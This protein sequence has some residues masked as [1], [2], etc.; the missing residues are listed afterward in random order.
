MDLLNLESLDILKWDSLQSH[1]DLGKEVAEDPQ[2]FLERITEKP[3]DL[4]CLQATEEELFP[5][6]PEPIS[7]TLGSAVAP[8]FSIPSRSYFCP[9]PFPAST[10][11]PFDIVP[12]SS[13][14]PL[15]DVEMDDLTGLGEE[16]PS[17]GEEWR[18]FNPITSSQ[19]QQK[20][21][22]KENEDVDLRKNSSDSQFSNESSESFGL[23]SSL[24]YDDSNT[25][26]KYCN[27][28]NH[29]IENQNLQQLASIK[30][31]SFNVNLS[32]HDYTKNVNELVSPSCHPMSN[33][34]Y[35]QKQ[36]VTNFMPHPFLPSPPPDYS[37]R[38]NSNGDVSIF[39]QPIYQQ[40]VI[41]DKSTTSS[42]R[43]ETKDEEKI[44][45]CTYANCGKVYAK[46][47]HLKVMSE[48]AKII[49]KLS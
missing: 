31:R 22:G 25:A 43:T 36:I 23:F 11:F 6:S 37:P 44:F 15:L 45:Q 30:S 49:C 32:G 14:L 26:N 24:L 20:I 47:S 1:P 19:H 35:H 3:N 48:S 8:R 38:G 18:A 28:S 29:R 34:L 46:S 21:I 9:N 5:P 33:G 39:R 12:P 4:L 41:V 13:E 17:L 40:H 10:P 42:N 7:P 2:S 16:I 27:V